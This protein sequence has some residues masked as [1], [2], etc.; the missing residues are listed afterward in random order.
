MSSRECNVLAIMKIQ[1]DGMLE[2]PSIYPYAQKTPRDIFFDEKY[3][4]TTDEGSKSLTLLSLDEHMRISQRD[5]I[6]L[7]NAMPTCIQPV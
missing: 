2:A 4:I 7:G 1:N 3:V 5:R 6:L